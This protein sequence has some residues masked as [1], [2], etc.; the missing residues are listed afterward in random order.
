M[1]EMCISSGQRRTFSWKQ[2]LLLNNLIV[3]IYECSNTISQLFVVIQKVTTT[4]NNILGKNLR[5][6]KVLRSA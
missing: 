5:I 3:R 1:R 2:I 6:L 4:K